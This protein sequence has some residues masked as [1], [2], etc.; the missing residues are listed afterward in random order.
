MVCS[1]DSSP[2]ESSVLTT[3]CTESSPSEE[4]Q[5]L[6]PIVTILSLPEH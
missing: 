2:E 1:A 3:S 5:A 4:V 6:P